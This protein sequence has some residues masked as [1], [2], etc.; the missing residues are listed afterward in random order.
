MASISAPMA[1]AAS[2]ARLSIV[3]P[4]S[5]QAKERS[6]ATAR[7]RRAA[8]TRT[9]AVGAGLSAPLTKSALVATARAPTVRRHGRTAHA[10]AGGP[11][12]QRPSLAATAITATLGYAWLANQLEAAARTQAIPAGHRTWRVAAACAIPARCSASERSPK[13]W[14]SSKGEGLA[15]LPLALLVILQDRLRIR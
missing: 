7:A 15:F 4:S 3:S 14:M 12:V 13:N 10:R 11:N 6:A 1:A 9:I 5:G 2:A 8:S